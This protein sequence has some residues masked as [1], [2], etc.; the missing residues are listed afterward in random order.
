MNL[1]WVFKP[2]KSNWPQDPK[3]RSLSLGAAETKS[4]SSN[5]ERRKMAKFARDTSEVE[6]IRASSLQTEFE[7]G[8]F[9][10]VLDLMAAAR[11]VGKTDLVALDS[12]A[13]RRGEGGRVRPARL[14]TFSR[15]VDVFPPA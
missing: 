3:Q 2:Q 15:S 1:K 4:S 6:W 14:N 8:C 5:N 12:G 9:E 11:S 10:S 7:S 13:M